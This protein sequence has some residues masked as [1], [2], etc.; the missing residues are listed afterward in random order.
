VTDK[1]FW[2]AFRQALLALVAAI[3]RWQ[4]LGKYSCPQIETSTKLSEIVNKTDL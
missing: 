1:E 3:E 4:K 2:I